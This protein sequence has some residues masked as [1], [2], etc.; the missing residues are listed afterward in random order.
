MGSGELVESFHFEGLS[1]PVFLLQ[2]SLSCVLGFLLVL[3]TVMCTQYNSALTTTIIGCL[4]NILITYLGM[5]IGSDYQ[6]SFLNFIGL[7][8]S[9]IGSL[10]YTKVTFTSKSN[11]PPPLPVTSNGK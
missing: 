9:V 6:Y 1:D 2:L 7:N 5:F 11:I 3:S 8:I 10:V 4:K